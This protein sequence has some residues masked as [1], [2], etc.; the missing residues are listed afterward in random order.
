MGMSM[1]KRNGSG[2]KKPIIIGFVAALILA[3]VL[4]VVIPVPARFKRLLFFAMLFGFAFL[5]VFITDRI[6]KKG[7]RR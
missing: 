7:G 6:S 3:V 1:R 4:V 2:D 5:S